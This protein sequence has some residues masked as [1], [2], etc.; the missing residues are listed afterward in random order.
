MCCCCDVDITSVGGVEPLCGLEVDNAGDSLP[1]LPLLLSKA[2][3]NLG[4][5]PLPP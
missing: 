5:P 2:A 3:S 1:L 4:E